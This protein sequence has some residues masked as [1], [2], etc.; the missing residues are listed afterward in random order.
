MPTNIPPPG[1]FPRNRV[2]HVLAFRAGSA[3]P[4]HGTGWV[5]SRR[6]IVTAAHVVANAARLEI[7]VGRNGS[8]NLCVRKPVRSAITIH[9]GWL[10]GAPSDHDLAVVSVATLPTGSLGFDAFDDG[11]LVAK[12]F[13]VAGYP[14]DQPQGTQ[15]C[16]A[17]SI[18]SVSARR[19]RYDLD[20]GRGFSGAPLWFARAGGPF[21]VGVHT[22]KK[23]ASSQ[24]VRLTKEKVTWIEDLC[25]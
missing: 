1:S 9:P 20:T 11:E 2:A 24:A 5:A 15:V 10:P 4:E 8:T 13:F 6:C 16:C 19:C 25:A 18:A 22:D 3:I 14:I 7:V 23:T 17:V 21:V 12:P